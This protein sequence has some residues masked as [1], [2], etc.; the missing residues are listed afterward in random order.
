MLY[1]IIELLRAPY[2]VASRQT[3]DSVLGQSEWDK[4][5]LRFWKWFARITTAILVGV[6]VIGWIIWKLLAH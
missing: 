6:P 2:E 5:S 3:E 1:E 4:R